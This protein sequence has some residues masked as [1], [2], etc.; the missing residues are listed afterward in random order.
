MPQKAWTAQR[1]RQYE[2]IKEA[3]LDRGGADRECTRMA[4]ATVNKTRR[5]KGELLHPK[6]KPRRRR[7][8][9]GLAGCPQG[10]VFRVDPPAP[11]DTEV[12][13]E[14]RH[15]ATRAV[16]G[17][18]YIDKGAPTVPRGSW[19]VA[20]IRVEPEVAR[21]G[22]GT[23]LYEKALEY[24]CSR[25][26]RLVSDTVRAKNAEA[27]WQKQV[28]KGRAECIDTRQGTVLPSDAKGRGAPKKWPCRVFA[29][30]ACPQGAADLSGLRGLRKRRHRTKRH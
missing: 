29:I 6:R 28:S 26:E 23:R 21:C 17:E 4:A 5:R 19:K 30:T 12:L 14:A 1:E 27:F 13:I 22:L 18:L 11:G 2:H 10:V 16:L 20:W 24:A 3:C 25:G 8:L 7:T 9:A 15:P